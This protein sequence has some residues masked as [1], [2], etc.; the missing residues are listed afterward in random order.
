MLASRGVHITLAVLVAVVT[1]YAGAKLS[2]W[3][4]VPG[5]V[6]VALLVISATD[7][8]EYLAIQRALRAVE[9]DQRFAELSEEADRMLAE[10]LPEEAEEA[11]LL[12]GEQRDERPVVIARYIHLA[13][14]CREMSD[15]KGARKWLTRAKQVT[16]A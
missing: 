4:Y 14:R 10:D 9:S 3:L 1:V 2:P 16:R 12:A 6:L 7:L 13:R 5:A 15:Y 8:I 11:Y